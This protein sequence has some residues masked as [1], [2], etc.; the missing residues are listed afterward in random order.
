[1]KATKPPREN[2]S[3]LSFRFD[4]GEPTPTVPDLIVLSA[5]ALALLARHDAVE[6]GGDEGAGRT[7]SLT[8]A[9]ADGT[10]LIL[11]C[12][13][14]DLPAGIPPQTAHPSSIP[15]DRPWVG[16]YRLIV[17]AP[18]VV[19]DLYW[20]PDDPL[21]IMGFSRGDWEQALLALAA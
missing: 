3:S 6:T 16:T 20:R 8:T 12:S 11:S 19:L 21:R 14:P 1:M 2:V 7:W 5:A 4:D 17:R 15:V 10:P 18:L 13:G 9:G